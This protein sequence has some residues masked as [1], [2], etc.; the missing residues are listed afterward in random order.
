MS[1]DERALGVSCL[2]DA[3]EQGANEVA[4]PGKAEM[5]ISNAFFKSMQEIQSSSSG[6][7]SLPSSDRAAGDVVDTSRRASG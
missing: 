6:R 7:G 2:R 5:L 3:G 4:D 1:A